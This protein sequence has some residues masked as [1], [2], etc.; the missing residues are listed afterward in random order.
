MPKS[1]SN[2]DAGSG[3]LF[4]LS[5]TH[6]RQFFPNGF[7][8]QLQQAKVLEGL[9]DAITVAEWQRQLT[10]HRPRVLV[11]GWGAPA[12]SNTFTQPFGGSIDYVCHVVGSVRHLVS[13]E[14]VAGGLRVSNWGELAAPLVAE[15]ALL[16]VLAC[17]RN[18]P[19]WPE[20]MRTPFTHDE[21]ERLA[22]R[23]LQEKHVAIH[24][25]G[26]VARE[27]VRMLQPFSVS[28]AAFSPGVPAEFIARY[29]VPPVGSARELCA[30]ADVIV[31]CE[32]LNP[33]TN[34]NLDREAL[35]ALPHGAVFV[36]VGRG[37]VVDEV[38]LAEVARERQLRV[39]SD[40]FTIEPLPADSPLWTL[41]G[42]LISPHLA[43]P[44]IDQ[45]PKCGDFAL[46]NIVRHL[47]GETPH[48]LI[49]P[50]IYDRA[51]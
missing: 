51:T 42:S 11:T 43:G 5:E 25:F 44:T 16:M 29:G 13:R 32:A 10:L 19:A 26:A 39:A 46:Q 8:R 21:K 36:N 49:T 1:Q 23:S 37:A 33:R 2:P 12:I 48:G 40:V 24:G 47:A 27:L 28:I 34:R 4:A 38:A 20:F 41:P 22:T 14:T 31:S 3:V 18:L 17:L 6:L 50:E 45:Y 9:T 7:G 15:H 35:N 30:G